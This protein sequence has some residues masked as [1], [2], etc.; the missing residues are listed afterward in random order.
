MPTTDIE[1]GKMELDA[2]DHGLSPKPEGK[3]IE[4]KGKPI[5]LPSEPSEGNT[6]NPIKNPKSDSQSKS[7]SVA[8]KIRQHQRDLLVAPALPLPLPLPEPIPEETQQ[9]RNRTYPGAFAQPGTRGA[10]STANDQV[11]NESSTPATNSEDSPNTALV[12]VTPLNEDAQEESSVV[13]VNED[14]ITQQR[15]QRQRLEKLRRQRDACAGIALVAILLAVVLA[16]L[17][18]GDSETIMQLENNKREPP[19]IS[20]SSSPSGAPSSALASFSDNL[21]Q[22]TQASLQNISSP[23]SQAMNWVLNYPNFTTFE[24]WRQRQLFALACFYYSFAGHKWID[25]VRSDWLLTDKHECYWYNAHFGMITAEGKFLGVPNDTSH[26]LYNGSSCNPRGELMSLAVSDLN[27]AGEKPAIP[28]ELSILTSLTELNL[29][30]NDITTSIQA[31]I[32]TQLYSM[33]QLKIINLLANS[34]S[35]TIS[36]QFGLISDLQW[37]AL[38]F[39]FFVSGTIPSELGQLTQLT[40]LSLSLNSFHGTIPSELGGMAS[41]VQ[42]DLDSL[43]LTGFIPTELGRLANLTGLSLNSNFLTAAVPTQLGQLTRL[44]WGCDLNS[45]SLTGAVPS[46]LGQLPSLTALNLQENSL[47]GPLPSQLGLL[48]NMVGFRGHHN[49]FTGL[50]SELGLLLSLEN[51]DLGNNLLS[52]TI[53]TEVGTLTHLERLKLTGNSLVG[54]IPSQL[55]LMSSLSTMDLSTNSLEGT[56]PSELGLLPALRVLDLSNLPLLTGSIPMGMGADTLSWLNLSASVGLDGVVPEDICFLNSAECN[57]TLSSNARSTACNLY[58]D[59]GK[60]CGCGCPCS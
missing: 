41:L 32:P 52:S 48:S 28:P 24:E 36:T 49:M 50:P 54:P 17:L 53:P 51:L 13:A 26:I 5:D 38:D 34:M 23:Q 21:P 55:G 33:T 2:G 42:L 60:L 59:C 45:N 22:Y 4:P 47:S 37:L 39:N 12:E 18:T 58:F 25:I 20:L 40:R 9:R 56:V 11:A 30:F 57:Y 29:F 31:M 15:T 46:E 43:S 7:S 6:E 3:V 1:Q 10:R 44:F 14:Q 19:T 8:G 27:L 35:G 16:V